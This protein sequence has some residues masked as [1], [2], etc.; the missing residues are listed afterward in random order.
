VDEASDFLLKTVIPTF[1][2]DLLVKVEKV[3]DFAAL[4][5]AFLLHRAGILDSL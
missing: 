5:V 1:A 4:D 3:S 2:S